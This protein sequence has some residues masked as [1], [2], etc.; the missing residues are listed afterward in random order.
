MTGTFVVFSPA[1]LP[2]RNT[3]GL[4]SLMNMV[5]GVRADADSSETGS[6]G[7]GESSD[8]NSPLILNSSRKSANGRNSKQLQI[9]TRPDASLTCFWSEL[10]L[11]QSS[12]VCERGGAF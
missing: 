10:Y 4:N 11:H 5:A 2:D 12:S 1:V 8:R 9:S 3:G 7:H 6:V